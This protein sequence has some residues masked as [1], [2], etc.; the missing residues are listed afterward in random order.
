MFLRSA[1]SSGA[2]WRN[3]MRPGTVTKVPS[4]SRNRR[5]GKHDRKGS[6]ESSIIALP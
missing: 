4:R 1:W 5:F 6:A 3:L 2:R